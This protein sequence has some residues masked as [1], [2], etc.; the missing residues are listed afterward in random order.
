MIRFG[1]DQD[2]DTRLDDTKRY[3][4]LCQLLV[5]T[6]AGARDTTGGERATIAQL[7]HTT[8]DLFGRETWPV[9]LPA[10]KCVVALGSAI[11]V[12]MN[13]VNTSI[14]ATGNQQR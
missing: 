13:I 10:D 4:F 14:D 2:D 12:V 9:T 7:E 1:D 11:P 8:G 5:N 6:S 3:P